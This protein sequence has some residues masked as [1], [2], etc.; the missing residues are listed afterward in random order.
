MRDRFLRWWHGWYWM[1]PW[2]YIDGPVFYAI[3]LGFWSLVWSAEK[4]WVP[5]SGL[6]NPKYRRF[7]SIEW[8]ID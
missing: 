2:D 7:L 3:G 1:W 5:S 4:L 8:N 6:D